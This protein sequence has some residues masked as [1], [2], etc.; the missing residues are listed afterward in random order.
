MRLH[1]ARH[2]GRVGDVHVGPG[3]PLDLVVGERG[4]PQEILAEHAARAENEHLHPERNSTG[5]VGR[6]LRAWLS[7][8]AAVLALAL[9]APVLAGDWPDPSAIRVGDETVAVATSGDSAPIFRVLRSPD[10]RSWRI[11]GSVFVRRPAL[12]GARLLGA[13]DHP[14]AERRASRSS[15]ARASRTGSSGTASGWRPPPAPEGPW[16]DLGQA[17]ALHQ[18]RVDR[19]LPDPRRARPAAPAVEGGRQ[20]FDRPTPI[21]A[22]RWREDGRRLIGRPRELIRNNPRA[23]SARWSRRAHV[24]RRG[25]YFYL[26]YSGGLCCTRKCAYAVG[27]ARVEDACSA[28]GAST[29]ATR[30]CAAATAG[31][32]PATPRSW[33]ATALF[34]AYRAGYGPHR[35]PAAAGGTVHLRA[36]T[37]GRGSAT[38][39]RPRR[40]TGAA[41]T[42]FSDTFARPRAG[43]GVVRLAAR[44]GIRTGDGLRLR[45]HG[46]TGAGSTAV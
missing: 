5:T 28:A 34:H 35:R 39:G 33:T 41:R 20:R 8:P 17:A 30:S 38:A 36:P 12:G 40:A 42:A 13:G 3:E 31:A 11:A 27:V 44:R 45:A 15:T 37:A 43:V 16:R 7:R 32:A 6:V 25:G 9:P 14:P 29:R 18:V 24:E 22:Q 4:G 10:M 23:G 46:A 21:F 19:S 2:G 26:L 1:R